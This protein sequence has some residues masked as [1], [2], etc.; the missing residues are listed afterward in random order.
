MTQSGGNFRSIGWLM[1]LVVIAEAYCL[2]WRWA[3]LHNVAEYEFDAR[4]GEMTRL[5]HS[6]EARRAVLDRTPESRVNCQAITETVRSADTCAQTC[7]GQTSMF[8]DDH[9][10]RSCTCGPGTHA[11]QT[12]ILLRRGALL[13]FGNRGKQGE[14][15][16][17]ARSFHQLPK[18]HS[19]R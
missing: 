13:A 4:T 1:V 15:A 19:T 8:I 3:S 10:H 18:A 7:S 16:T 9:G 6:D 5:D 12:Q 14:R 2:Y 11:P 17:R